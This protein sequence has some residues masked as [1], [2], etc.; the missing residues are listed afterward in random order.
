MKYACAACPLHSLWLMAFTRY[1]RV[2][3][4][5]VGTR[6]AL[7]GADGFSCYFNV[8]IVVGPNDCGTIVQLGREL[9][10]AKISSCVVP[11]GDGI[12]ADYVSTH[13]R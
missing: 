10:T 7:G 4:Y 5:Y 3:E 11:V 12:K 13:S 8:Y 9:L 2:L 1:E 6:K